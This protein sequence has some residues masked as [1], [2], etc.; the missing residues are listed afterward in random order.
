MVRKAFAHSGQFKKKKTPDSNAPGLLASG[1]VYD[2]EHSK[3]RES[4][5]TVQKI[6]E[7]MTQACIGNT[8]Q[9]W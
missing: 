3:E 7:S 2:E 6:R 8:R 1:S 4:D 5:C 9:L